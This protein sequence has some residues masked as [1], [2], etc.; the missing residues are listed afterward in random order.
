MLLRL[1][2]F[3]R[4]GKNREI[5]SWLGGGTVV[6]VAGTWALFIYFF[7]HDENVPFRN[8]YIAVR[9]TEVR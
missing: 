8:R 1:W 2:K 6:I 4:N 5:L 3:V 9:R 7:P